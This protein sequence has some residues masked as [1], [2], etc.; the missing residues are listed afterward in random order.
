MNTNDSTETPTGGWALTM[1]KTILLALVLLSLVVVSTALVWLIASP[2]LTVGLIL[3]ASVIVFFLGL[4][5]LLFACDECMEREE[6]T[7]QPN[8]PRRSGARM[9]HQYWAGLVKSAV[10][11]PAVAALGIIIAYALAQSMDPQAQAQW[12]GML[13]NNAAVVGIWIG[14]LTWLVAGFIFS[15]SA[16]AERG[17]PAAFYPLKARLDSLEFEIDQYEQTTGNQD[18]GGN[19]NWQSVAYKTANKHKCHI[20]SQIEKSG[21]KWVNC[22]GYREVWHRLYRAEEAL[23]HLYPSEALT[24]VVNRDL[25]SLDNSEIPNWKQL[26]ET[27][28][29][30]ANDAGVVTYPHVSPIVENNGSTT[31]KP[32]DIE[33]LIGSL[34]SNA[35]QDQLESAMRHDAD[36]ALA[37]GV[38]QATVLGG[39]QSTPIEANARATIALVR[40]ELNTFREGLVTKFIQTRN[41]LIISSYFTWLAVLALLA[42][43]VTVGNVRHELLYGAT[44]YFFTG[45]L[46]GLIN[47]LRHDAND[48]S[49]ED[50]YGLSTT[51]LLHIP[52]FSGV[53]AVTGVFLVALAG[54]LPTSQAGGQSIFDQAFIIGS[55]PYGLIIAAAFGLTPDLLFH[56]LRKETEVLKEKSQSTTPTETHRNHEDS[57]ASHV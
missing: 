26:H 48:R 53:A 45:A 46:V 41:R 5:S 24:D 34:L 55:Y 10:V 43:V 57:K 18:Q 13:Q 15:L 16:R 52:L 22:W 56:H 3:I 23:I 47:R 11:F 30:A 39:R 6:D 40:R 38:P 37:V 2:S 1:V 36:T 49:V 8:N 29:Q 7:K 21:M 9:F 27:L 25:L 28:K 33:S 17:Y 42:F 14:L 50:D 4:G 12:H 54:Q 20:R 44:I 31:T 32:R 19:P 51:L 35:G